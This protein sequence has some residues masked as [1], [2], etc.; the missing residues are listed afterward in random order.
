MSLSTRLAEILSNKI[1]QYFVT[2]AREGSFSKAA[3]KLQYAQS[4]LSLRIKQLEEELNTTLFQRTAQGVTLTEQGGILLHYA[5]DLLSLKTT[6]CEAVQ[7]GEQQRKIRVGAME[8]AAVSF[9]PRMLSAFHAKYTTISITVT[10]GTTKLCLKRL[11]EGELDCAFVVC[12]AMPCEL[13]YQELHRERLVLLSAHEEHKSSLEELL[14]RPLLV[15]PK[16]CSYR[17]ILERF[18]EDQGIYNAKRMEF[19]S[20]GAIIASASAGLGVTFFP[21]SA[22]DAFTAASVLDQ[23]VVPD[24][25]G[26]V[27]TRFVYRKDTKL[28]ALFSALLSLRNP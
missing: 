7:R 15:F 19:D 18:L 16:G 12:Q 2:I 8:S 21:A 24:C 22:M 27:P 5:E 25:Y 26:L 28:E 1:L 9:V 23:H 4:N 10:T 17:R 6:A 3:R 13:T 20:L 11:V 14:H